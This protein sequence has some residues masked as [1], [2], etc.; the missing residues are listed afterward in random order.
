MSRTADLDPRLP[1][2]EG[3]T[4]FEA[5]VIQMMNEIDALTL[6]VEDQ[7]LQIK[8]QGDA[9]RAQYILIRRLEARAKAANPASADPVAFYSRRQGDL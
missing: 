8:R 6:K 7:A 2:R 5:A 3:M 1:Q 4:P 9:L